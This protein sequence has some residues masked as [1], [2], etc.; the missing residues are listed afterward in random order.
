ML[1]Q[2]VDDGRWIVKSFLATICRIES[3]DGKVDE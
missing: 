2:K 1:N 3:S